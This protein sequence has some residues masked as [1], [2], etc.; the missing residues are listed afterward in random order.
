MSWRRVRNYSSGTT[1][2]ST[3]A[4]EKVQ[5]ACTAARSPDLASWSMRRRTS[6][7]SACRRNLAHTSSA[8]DAVAA[9]T[10][11]PRDVSR[12]A[13]ACQ[14]SCTCRSRP[15]RP[16]TLFSQK[17][18]V[19]RHPARSSSRRSSGCRIAPCC[20][21]R[22][23]RCRGVGS[24]RAITQA[25]V[26]EAPCGTS[27][28]IACE[29][30]VDGWGQPTKSVCPLWAKDRIAPAVTRPGMPTTQRPGTNS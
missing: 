18:S 23:R 29:F 9:I 10:A 3:D 24:A 7:S 6:A 14:T 19:V 26:N 17:S 27:V 25:I 13:S 5:D 11:T 2:L 4:W 16:R 21:S 22:A 12:S 30:L 15:S 28:P 8:D 20:R 1:A